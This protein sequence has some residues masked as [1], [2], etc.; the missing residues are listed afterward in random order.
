MIATAET[1]VEVRVG[2]T[3]TKEFPLRNLRLQSGL[4]AAEVVAQGREQTPHFP[5][6][7][8]HLYV[9]EMRGTY[10]YHILQALA[11]IYQ[12]SIEEVVRVADPVN[13]RVH[14]Q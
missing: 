6:T 4:S 2:R 14:K 11:R 13:T 1:A 12:L 3:Q 5:R 7:I 10:H 9:L 8:S